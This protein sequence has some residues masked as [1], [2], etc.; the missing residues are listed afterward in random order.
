MNSENPA[1]E[2]AL[3][4]VTV[5]TPAPAPE[6]ALPLAS[7]QMQL[8][9]SLMQPPA[10]EPPAIDF[11]IFGRALRRFWPVLVV[12][13]GLC[14]GA[15]WYYLKKTP[16]LYLAL[17]EIGV[18]QER[19]E[20]VP[21]SSMRGEDLK[22]LEMLKSIERQIA[23]QNV[24]LEV[25]KRFDLH[26]DPVL[27]GPDASRGLED[28]QVVM[29]LSRRV[30]ASLER[31][32]R[33]IVL[34]VEDTDPARAK[35]ICQTIIDL[36]VQRDPS[37]SSALKEKAIEALEK[38]AGDARARMDASQAA[39]NTFRAKFPALPLE[40]TPSDMKT[41]SFED[42]LK[43]LNTDAV[44]AADELSAMEAQMDRVRAAGTN[45]N[46]LLAVPGLATQET[47]IE[48][49]KALSEAQAKFAETDYGPK[50]PT[51]KAMQQQISEIAGGLQQT[52][53]TAAKVEQAK[54]EKARENTARI[55]REIAALKEQQ[56]QFAVVAGDFKKLSRELK[57]TG[58]AY[59]SV[60]ARLNEEKNNSSFGASA[61]R[62][63]A[64]PLVPSAPWKPRRMLT[65][66]A[67]GVAGAALGITLIALLML[68][69][70]SIRSVTSAERLLR[71]PCFAAMPR[72][73]LGD[74]KGRLIYGSQQ[75]SP[76]A[77]A[78]RGLRASLATAGRVPGARSFLFTSARSGEGKSSIA[79]NF[80][81]SLAQQGYRTLIIDANLRAPVLDE[82]LLSD[83]AETGLADYLSGEFSADAKLCRQTERP[84][85][86][87]FSAGIPKAHPAEILHEPAFSR[88]IQESLKWFHRVVIDTAAAG[89][90]A[91]TLPLARHADAVCLV[92]RAGQTRRS[93]VTKAVNR[94]AAAGARPAGFVLNAAPDA[95]MQ[96]SFAG[97][98][99]A[100]FRAPVMM[101]ALPPARA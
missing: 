95:A 74:G 26:H 32:T 21:S 31:G 79:V 86:F 96:E 29:A 19:N 23:G 66:A 73:K 72:L 75:D 83:R 37:A 97:D 49:R 35:E 59:S 52:L 34:S 81:A 62:V 41:N 36:V 27:A 40:E 7:L 67:G 56:H 78:V 61:L 84:N 65:L 4:P 58:E 69:D 43:V 94:L 71:M 47:V 16:T 53:L 33:N 22:S 9:S 28:D 46:A 6:A 45:S 63:V 48:L 15:A 101:P 30:T 11:G 80:A 54:Y 60:L 1:A 20:L 38:Q 3:T 82:V 57:S 93:E 25:G 89:Q 5:E 39:V 14:V 64:D 92:V 17:G 24:L 91:D 77:E 99:A 10:P 51:Y 87:L 42:R 85:L 76:A 98:Y 44:K 8:L 70:R 88:L 2:T 18:V 12:A 90:F 50:H 68:L 55:E 13:T 100:A